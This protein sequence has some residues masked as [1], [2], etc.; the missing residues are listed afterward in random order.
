MY[1]ELMSMEKYVIRHKPVSVNS[2]YIPHSRKFSKRLSS[3]AV[4]YKEAVKHQVLAQSP[5]QYDGSVEIG[6]I[7]Y[8]KDRRKRDSENYLKA[9]TDA[10]QGVLFKDD[11]QVIIGHHSKVVNHGSW[12]LEIF[13]KELEETC[14]VCG[15]MDT[16]FK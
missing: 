15:K 14:D 1:P 5:V 10:L 4:K 16:L 8:F 2:M 13:I 12:K 6:Y 9:T 7:F 11:N 3:E